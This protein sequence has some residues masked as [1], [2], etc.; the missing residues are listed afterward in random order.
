[1]C[2][3]HVS[4]SMGH[5]G[6]GEGSWELFM[7]RVSAW[8]AGEQGARPAAREEG[9]TTQVG[10]KWERGAGPQRCAQHREHEHSPVLSLDVSSASLCHAPQ[11]PGTAEGLC[12]PL[13]PWDHSVPGS[14]PRRRGCAGRVT[15]PSW[16]P[17]VSSPPCATTSCHT[18][19][20]PRCDEPMLTQPPSFPQR[21]PAARNKSETE[22]G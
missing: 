16:D 8:A 18:L 5:P 3:V 9:V 2:R 14:A 7:G 20:Q 4:A 10:Y 17:S 11:G 13:P 22:Q 19:G 6:A 21:V 15:S 1:M 12:A